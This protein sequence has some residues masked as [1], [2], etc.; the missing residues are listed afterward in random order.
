MRETILNWTSERGDTD[1]DDNALL[2]WLGSQ[3]EDFG[4]LDDIDG[5]GQVQ[6]LIVTIPT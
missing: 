1:S 3:V 2:E 6:S 5:K 4:M